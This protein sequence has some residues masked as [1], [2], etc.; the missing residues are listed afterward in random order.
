MNTTQNTIRQ[1]DTITLKDLILK[2]QEWWRYLL[3][4]WL[5]IVIFGLIGAG[6]GLV[7]S[8]LGKISYIGE[9]TF[10]L[11]D[12]Q[13][14]P[15]S[16]Y[17]GL[18]SQF[19]IDLGGNSTSGVFTGDNI[20]E[21]LQSRL[22]IEK[23]LLS[24]IKIDGK[25]MSLADLYIDSYEMRD[26]WANKPALKALHF[27]PNADRRK[28]S[29]QQDS[30]LSLIHKEITENRLEIDKPD[31]KLNFISVRCTT[32]SEAFSQTF[33]QQLVK[34]ATGFY[35]DTKTKRN[36]VNVDRLQSQADSLEM[37][38]NRKTF[39][40][41]AA[42]DLNLNPARQVAGVSSE[43]AMRDK[44]VLQTMYGEVVKNLELSKIAMAHETPVIQIVDTPI[45]PLERKKFG[46][47]KGLVLGGF[48]GGVLI[49]LALIIK[50]MYRE[51]MS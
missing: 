19:G 44:L 10:V 14:N 24:P 33:T 17:M 42:Q 21:F 8:L 5:L 34:E 6:L 40:A 13:G 49:V 39:S 16:S 31:K 41:A 51:I 37:M 46:K 2:L 27:P 32:V 15:L 45:L 43:L 3:S 25:V 28:F 30:I 29:R 48:L 7:R 22:M 36:K 20:I 1:D 4:K 11:E 47:L 23:S 26:S 35:V 12:N 18:A 38:L 50:K 9:L